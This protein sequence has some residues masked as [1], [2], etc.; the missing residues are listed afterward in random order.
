[1]YE[2]GVRVEILTVTAPFTRSAL[3]IDV[4]PSRIWILPVG[5]GLSELETS[6]EIME[7]SQTELDCFSVIVKL[8]ANGWANDFVE[9]ERAVSKSTSV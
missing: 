4:A 2:P 8:G 3:A 5:I 1:M 9:I 6:K 7:F